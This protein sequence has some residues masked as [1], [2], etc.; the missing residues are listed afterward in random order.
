MGFNKR[1]INLDNLLYR[2]QMEDGIEEVKRFITKPDALIIA[3]DS[4][5]YIVDK[6]RRGDYYGAILILDYELSR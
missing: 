4:S 2:Y 3:T 1:F 5:M 6:I